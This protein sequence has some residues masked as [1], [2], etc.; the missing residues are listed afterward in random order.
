MVGSRQAQA[1]QT[2]AALK[3]AART[4][5]A[6]RGYLNTKIADITRAAGRS[7]GSFYNHFTSKEDLLDALAADLATTA[8]TLIGPPDG[9]PHDLS[10]PRQLRRH[11]AVFWQVYTTHHP[12]ITAMRQAALVDATLA[13]RMQAI[14][15]AQLAPWTSHLEDLAARGTPL[16]GPPATLAAAMATLTESLCEAWLTTPDPTPADEVLDTLTALL[17][18]GLTRPTPHP[19]SQPTPPES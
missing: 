10:D 8:D 16:A 4:L 3:Q 17:S 18:H 15:T 19:D 9:T 7:A 13:A 5:F 12:E 1:A 2:A 6:E 14:R 11:L